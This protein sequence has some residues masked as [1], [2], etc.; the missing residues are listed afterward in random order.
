VTSS[1]IRTPKI[2]IGSSA[3]ITDV[4]AWSHVS[5]SG[6]QISLCYLHPHVSLETVGLCAMLD[7]RPAPD[8]V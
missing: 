4:W 5:V 6:S 3:V 8:R 2:G 1:G 7:D